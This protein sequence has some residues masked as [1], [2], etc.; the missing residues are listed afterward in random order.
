MDVE[1]LVRQLSVDVD[2]FRESL[3]MDVLRCLGVA[4]PPR[5]YFQVISNPTLS[6]KVAHQIE[7]IF[8]FEDREKAEDTIK[9]SDHDSL[10]RATV[11]IGKKYTQ[12]KMYADLAR[13]LYS[14][15]IQRYAGKIRNDVLRLAKLYGVDS[16]ETPDG[17]NLNQEEYEKCLESAWAEI[18]RI[19]YRAV[20]SVLPA[21][22]YRL[23]NI[24]EV[25]FKVNR[26]R[27]SRKNTVGENIEATQFDLECQLE[28]KPLYSNEWIKETWGLLY[29]QSIPYR[30]TDSGSIGTTMVN[31]KE[32]L[33]EKS[34]YIILID[35]YW[36]VIFRNILKLYSIGDW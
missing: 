7:Y 5:I 30:T 12:E 29:N 25:Y 16:V 32:T 35:G 24:Q 14:F 26:S 11:H 4:S 9:I 17:R 22:L 8:D 27:I 1:K 3:R 34:F 15:A 10:P 36:D 2:S 23:A 19:M 6:R 31:W 18:L 13:N 28:Y 33:I 20:S 21:D